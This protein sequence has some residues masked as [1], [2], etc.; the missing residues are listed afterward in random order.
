VEE[1]TEK[2]LSVPIT[3]NNLPEGVQVNLFPAQVKVS[4]MIGLS[5]FAKVSPQDFKA[6]VSYEDLQ[7]N[8]DYLPVKIEKK[9]SHLESVNYLPKK[10]EY[11]IEK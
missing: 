7:N 2:Q 9:P 5:Q 3:V 11:L 6:S 8:L 10:V 1:Y 4:F